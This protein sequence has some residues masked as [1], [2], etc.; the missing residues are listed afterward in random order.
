MY[1]VDEN[2]KKLR[3]TARQR[4]HESKS[5]KNH[6]IF[7]KKKKHY[8]AP[9]HLTVTLTLETSGYGPKTLEEAQRPG[10]T[11]LSLID[12]ETAL[13]K[14]NACTV[15]YEMFKDYIAERMKYKEAL[16]DFYGELF[17]KMRWRQY[18]NT[19]KSEEKFLN[20]VEKTDGKD[21][22]L[23]Y[24]KWSRRS[25]MKQFMPTIGAGLRKLLS[26][27]FETISVDECKT[28]KLCCNCEKELQHQGFEGKKCI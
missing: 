25:Q 13:C 11:G 24:D 3:Y 9:K 20:K 27:V 26:K 15:D 5:R 6:Q 19:K 14:H 10:K 12:V 28:S 1:M 16:S 23:A 7:L 21:I 17:R 22:V 8:N 18:V 4:R 2:W